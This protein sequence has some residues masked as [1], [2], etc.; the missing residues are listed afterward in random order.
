[1]QAAV[2]SAS[3]S[4]FMCRHGI[5][6]HLNTN[7]THDLITLLSDKQIHPNSSEGDLQ[8][9]PVTSLL[10]T[11]RSL[12]IVDT[13][14][15][16]PFTSHGDERFRPTICNSSHSRLLMSAQRQL[17]PAQ[18]V[19]LV[20]AASSVVNTLRPCSVSPVLLPGLCFPS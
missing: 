5:C 7:L 14:Q 6:C 17:C 15:Q 1:M 8:L 13:R 3:L 11:R 12:I 2:L 4:C 10:L 16:N 9:F 20:A 18:P 19:L